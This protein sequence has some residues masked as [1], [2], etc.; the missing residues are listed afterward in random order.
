MSIRKGSVYIAGNNIS[1]DGDTISYN[2]N[3]SLQANGVINKN[4]TAVDTIKYDWVGTTSEYTTQNISTLHPDWLCYITDDDASEL[5]NT[6]WASGLG[7]PNTS[8]YE[9][10]T[11]LVSDSEYTAPA[12]GWF[13]ARGTCRS[14]A[15]VG[16]VRLINDTNPNM[17]IETSSWC[18]G[19]TGRTVSV[20]LPMKAGDT[21]KFV[22]GSYTNSDLKMTFVY[23][24][25]NGQ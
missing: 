1:I 7:M 13:F 21:A 6:A 2:S 24:E 4:P 12:N 16:I 15:S 14:G 17:L 11:V 8:R 20:F 18:S 23:A 19:S 5:L 25:G 10:L 22:Y 3:N 9:D